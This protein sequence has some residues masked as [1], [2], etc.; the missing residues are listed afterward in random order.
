VGRPPNSLALGIGHHS[1][2]DALVVFLAVEQEDAFQRITQ[3]RLRRLAD[4]EARWP[5][6]SARCS[7]SRVCRPYA[8]VDEYE[9]ASEEHIAAGED[10]ETFAAST[11]TSGTGRV[12]RRRSRYQTRPRRAH[13]R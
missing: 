1:R 5:A 13:A 2:P 3:L 6:S 4:E 9:Q 8:S 12:R 11:S 7:A 10:I